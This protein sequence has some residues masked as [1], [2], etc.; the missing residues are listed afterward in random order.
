[1]RNVR[2]PTSWIAAITAA[3]AVAGAG[4]AV[5]VSSAASSSPSTVTAG[6]LKVKPGTV[7]PG[8]AVSTSALGTRVFPGSSTGFALAELSSGTYPAASSNGG[9][10]WKTDGPVLHENAAQAPL[11]VQWAGAANSHTFF[12]YGG[13]GG[14]QVVDVTADGGK[15]WYGAILGDVV[16]AVVPG[17]G[18][19]VA[20]VQDSTAG[21]SSV[22]TD[23]YVSTNG[24][25][26]WKLTDKFA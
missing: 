10:T 20:F 24:G 22:K 4:I 14:G 6:L 23:V 19:L 12:A 1:M 9:R 21:G 26:T 7:K 15:H 11:V 13:P 16:T 5:G 25:R 8:T 3:T 17:S 18:R 2:I